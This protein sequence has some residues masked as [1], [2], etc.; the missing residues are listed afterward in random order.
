[1]ESAGRLL[2]HTQNIGPVHQGNKLV[3]W[4]SYGSWV[5]LCYFGISPLGCQIYQTEFSMDHSA[6]LKDSTR[7]I[8]ESCTLQVCTP[9]V[10]IYELLKPNMGEYG[11]PTPYHPII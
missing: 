6:L 10:K 7:P 4:P 2:I 9:L 1:M 11:H 8:F 3:L 5:S